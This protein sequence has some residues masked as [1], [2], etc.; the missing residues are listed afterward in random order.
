M[1]G[2]TKDVTN[3]FGRVLKG[4]GN[5]FGA[6]DEGFMTEKCYC[7][8]YSWTLLSKKPRYYRLYHTTYALERRY[9]EQMELGTI[10]WYF[11]GEM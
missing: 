6:T 4:Q 10:R 1:E 5:T 9:G 8:L 11:W 7:N 2:Q 3:P